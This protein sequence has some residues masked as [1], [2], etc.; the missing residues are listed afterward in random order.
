[1][2]ATPRLDSRA[3]HA[4][5]RTSVVFEAV[6]LWFSLLGAVACTRESADTKACA[7]E[8]NTDAALDA[9]SRAIGAGRLSPPKL[10]TTL[11]N[12]GT[13][14]QRRGD[15]DLAIQDFTR[16]IE[17]RP[18]TSKAFYNRGMVYLSQG[19]FDRAI[20]DFDEA[21]RISPEYAVAFSN[22]GVAHMNKGTYDRAIADFDQAIRLKPD[23][24]H[25]YRGRGSAY[26]DKGEFKRASADL[27]RAAELHRGDPYTAIRLFLA[28]SRVGAHAAPG[29]AIAFQ[30]STSRNGRATSSRCTLATRPPTRCSTRRSVRPRRPSARIFARRTTTSATGS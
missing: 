1:M 19:E 13:A 14:Y 16:V 6:V 27:A 15:F 22:R 11:Y 17:L 4:A 12:R 20:Q 25:A 21:I 10:A 28:E 7:Q 3:G 29:S 30:A 8:A 26:Y 9:C 2:C 24:G 18:E 23:D 5:G